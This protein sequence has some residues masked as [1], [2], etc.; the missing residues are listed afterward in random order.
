MRAS[1]RVVKREELERAIWGDQPP[2][3]DALRAHMHTLRH[4]IEAPDEAPLIHNLR[5]IGYRMT[6]P[7]ALHP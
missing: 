7:D 3:S 4:A 2:D 1:P 5:G 6:P